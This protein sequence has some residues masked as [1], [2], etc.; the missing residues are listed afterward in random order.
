M[1]NT[2]N[3]DFIFDP[4]EFPPLPELEEPKS[5]DLEKIT[6]SGV[7]FDCFSSLLCAVIALSIIY[8][9]FFRLIDVDG[10]SM[11]NT[12]QDGEKLLITNFFFTPDYGDIVIISREFQGDTPLVKRVIATE[13]DK[14]DI[15]FFTGEVRVNETLLEEPYIAEI[16]HN[17]GDLTYPLVIPPGHVFVMGDNRNFSLDSRFSVVG[18]IDESRLLGKAIYKI[19]FIEEM[20]E[21]RNS[22]PK[23]FDMIRKLFKIK[24][25][26]A[27]KY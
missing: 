21:I 10:A 2:E 16:T 22:N 17:S 15:N 12:L 7:V 25:L 18:F 8:T 20:R 24:P 13:G 5:N 14:L 27:I 11:N 9:F 23:P 4:D 26:E 6:F 19:K 3:N 1:E